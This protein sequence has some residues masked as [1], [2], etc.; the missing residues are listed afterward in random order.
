M[1]I[2]FFGLRQLKKKHGASVAILFM[3]LFDLFGQ[4]AT[5]VFWTLTPQQAAIYIYVV[6]K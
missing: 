6:V 4:M 1:D 3:V 5:T 2:T